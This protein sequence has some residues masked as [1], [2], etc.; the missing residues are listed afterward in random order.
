MPDY[1]ENLIRKKDDSPTEN[2]KGQGDV[3]HARTPSGL[4]L[5]NPTEL[6]A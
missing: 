3:T 5:K 6:Y 2:P 4:K 1:P